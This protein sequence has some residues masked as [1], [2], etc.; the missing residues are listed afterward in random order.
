MCPPFVGKMVCHVLA[1]E[2]PSAGLILVDTGL[3]SGDVASPRERLGREFVAITRPRLQAS[4]TALAQL[5]SLGFAAARRAPRHRRP[6]STST[7]PAAS[8][9]F[10]TPR[11]TSASPS[12]TPP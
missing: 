6:T 11:C 4:E 10:P 9:T 7:T 1:I 8:A 2:T 5:A 3:G 12:T